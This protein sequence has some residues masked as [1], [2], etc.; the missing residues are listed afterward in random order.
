MFNVL[1]ISVKMFYLKLTIFV[2]LL[3]RSNSYK[4]LAI[5]P[6]PARS[7]LHAFSSLLEALARKGHHVTVISYFPSKENIPNYRDIKI[8][9]IEPLHIDPA[10]SK[11]D[12]N[13]LM[14]TTP[15]FLG[16]FGQLTCDIGFNS[17]N[18]QAFLKEDNHFDLALVAHF[19]SDCFLALKKKYRIP[20]IRTLSCGLLPWS[21]Y[22]YGIPYNTAYMPNI[23]LD[24]SEK[25]T[26]LQRVVNTV[27]TFVLSVFYNNLVVVKK[28]KII[29]MKYFGKSGALLEEDIL[30][31]SLLLVNAHH[32][33]GFPIP[34]VPNV[35][36]VGGVHVV[37]PKE[38]TKVRF[39]YPI[40]YKDLKIISLQ[41][42]RYLSQSKIG[43]QVDVVQK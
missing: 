26:F 38:L 1:R 8:G 2:F 33:V 7:Q 13:I 22:R 42:Q 24:F 5:Y 30:N 29:S 12:L 14:Y 15:L 10:V 37:K 34:L 40:L 21:S 35:I 32:S 11:I 4:I 43:I 31:D 18:V 25:M 6:H 23:F 27:S 3:S 36:E 17:T 16:E 20:V 39:S 41:L 28:D 19:N 9:D